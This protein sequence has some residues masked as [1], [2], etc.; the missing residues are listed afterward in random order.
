MLALAN[1][2]GALTLAT[3]GITLWPAEQLRKLPAQ[4][5]LP[6]ERCVMI[7]AADV[8]RKFA[9][10]NPGKRAKIGVWRRDNNAV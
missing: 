7:G 9:R 2:P 1:L 3:P 6:A 8:V 5:V 10:I 4:L